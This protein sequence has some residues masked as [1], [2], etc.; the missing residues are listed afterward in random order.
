MGRII[1]GRIHS[2]SLKPNQNVKVLGQDGKL[3]ETG[4]ISKIL[5][6]RGL[7]RQPIE[8]G[9]AGDIVAIAGLQKVPLRILSVIQLLMNP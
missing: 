3:L 7:E 4:R 6:F 2:G 5:A 1:T 8:E 9:S